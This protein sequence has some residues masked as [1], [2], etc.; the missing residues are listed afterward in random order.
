[1]NKKAPI[2]LLGLFV[3]VGY[4]TGL[5]A[6]YLVEG[7]MSKIQQLV[8]GAT[9]DIKLFSMI[10]TAQM[11]QTMQEI[12]DSASISFEINPHLED[13]D[14]IVG[15]GD[16]FFENTIDMCRF[17]SD[18]DIDGTFFFNDDGQNSQFDNFDDG[19]CIVCKILSEE[20][21]PCED[22]I[23]DF[24]NLPDEST[25]NQINNA[26]ASD[27]ITVSAQAFSNQDPN[28]VII[29]DS[30][31]AHG[32]GDADIESP[33]A[34][35]LCAGCG[36]FHLVI[37]PEGV[38]GIAKS[39]A[40]DSA[41]GGIQTWKFDP[42]RLVR[43]F[44]FVDKDNGQSAEAR[45]YKNSDCTGLIKSEPIVD[46]GEGSVQTVF[47]NANNVRC[48]EIEYPDSG[49]VTNMDLECVL[50]AGQ[51]VIGMG[52][53]NF[54][55]G[56]TGS[57]TVEIPL[58]SPAPIWAGGVEINIQTLILDFVGFPA[59]TVLSNQYE[60]DY[61]ITISGEEFGSGDSLN[62]M[63]FDTN[64]NNTPDNDLEVNIGNISIIPHDDDNNGIPDLPPNDSP[65]GGIQRFQFD[66]VRYVNSLIFV[67][68]DRQSPI[69][70]Y[71]VR[72]YSDF[73]CSG[74]PFSTIQIDN[75]AGDGSTQVLVPVQ[76]EKVGCMEVEYNDSGGVASIN[77]G[78]PLPN[79]PFN[80][81]NLTWDQSSELKVALIVKEPWVSQLHSQIDLPLYNHLLS[82]GLVLNEDLFLVD[83]DDITNNWSP[84][85]GVNVLVISESV[86]S[87]KVSELKNFPIGIV[88]V[89]GYTW[90]ELDLGTSG[91]GVNGAGTSIN[92]LDNTHYITKEH[93][94][95]PV[96]IADISGNSG[97]IKGWT[98]NG[99][100]IDALGVYVSDSSEARL[101]AVE[102]GEKLADGTD[103][104]D[105]RVFLGA[106]YFANLN[107]VGENLFD[108]SLTWA[109]GLAS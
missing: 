41:A 37:I 97:Q 71:E 10:K 103:A 86:S 59:G 94:L 31:I 27:G 24:T 40:D 101:L 78:C 63:V 51:K 70:P 80:I 100:Q 58:Q 102:S 90:D 45:A 43:S 107:S 22:I 23:L 4:T 77:L 106:R 18:S 87:G 93:S 69:G 75:T 11:S 84:P 46:V 6:E 62:P 21:I 8:N 25:Q 95:G 26:L 42:P 33:V 57:E 76:V 108:R 47:M 13:P 30:D 88:T 52:Q 1:M 28:S 82:L 48:L 61:G 20:E 16:E 2:L 72:L 109:A 56:Y 29:F 14:G 50:G 17:H 92:I 99:A 67:D 98:A 36:G 32:T 66:P 35:G 55:N 74:T 49:G 83:D 34:G 79:D 9:M 5:G 3:V 7:E 12:I 96:T 68:A 53:R 85:T 54:G 44:V 65:N 73:D 64:D 91:D 39:P 38:N 60:A 104:A 81:S 19:I 15:N 89:E 105:R